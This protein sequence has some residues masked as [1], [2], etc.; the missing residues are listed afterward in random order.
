MSKTHNFEGAVNNN[1]SNPLLNSPI[2]PK[3]IPEIQP[4]PLILGSN[5]N[6][7]KEY[8]LEKIEE[9]NENLIDEFSIENLN[10]ESNSTD[11]DEEYIEIQEKFEPNKVKKLCILE[12]LKKVSREK[13]IYK[14]Q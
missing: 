10:N 12:M 6:I 9:L 13:N 4:S 11:E 8:L 2:I 1:Q 14:L 7:N 3:K 5:K